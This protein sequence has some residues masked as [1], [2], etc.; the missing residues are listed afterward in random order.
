MIK[1]KECFFNNH[2][3]GPINKETKKAVIKEAHILSRA[4]T[5]SQLTGEVNGQN[6]VYRA[7]TGKSEGWK[8][9]SAYHCF[10]GNHDDKVFKPIED[11]NEFNPKDKEHLF[12]HSFRSFAY[13]YHKKRIEMDNLYLF[14]RPFSGENSIINVLD[15]DELRK[16]F[17]DHMF[18][19]QRIKEKLVKIYENKNF[20]DLKYKVF[21]LNKKFPLASAGTLMANIISETSKS[22]VY[23][24]QTEPQLARPGIMLTVFPDPHKDQTN[25]ILACLKSNRNGTIFL[26]KFNGIGSK[27]LFLGLS[28]LMLITNR[29]NTFFH[30]AYWRTIQSNSKVNQLNRELQKKRGFDLLNGNL[31]LSEFNLFKKELTSEQLLLK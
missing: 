27:Q 8:K 11:D 19:H 20:D 22:I 5:M 10:C 14:F 25:I 2:N 17:A 4:A 1:Y 7:S 12:L 13:S 15:E 24:D 29:E 18:S 31:Q 23:Y 21:I 9:A 26:N 6:E 28:S 3:C 16:R 30:P